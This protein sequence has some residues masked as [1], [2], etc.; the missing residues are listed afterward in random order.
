MRTL[1]LTT[2][3]LLLAAGAALLWHRSPE[4]GR[5]AAPVM[6][7]PSPVAPKASLP[8]PMQ[9]AA[10]VAPTMP[11]LSEQ[12][13]RLIASGNPHAA[14]DAYRLLSNCATFNRDGDRLIFDLQNLRRSDGGLPGFRSMTDG[15]KAHDAHLCTGMTE[16]MRVARL[17]YL[18]M[19][20]RA[21]VMGAAIQ[22]AMEGPFGDLSALQTRPD[23][24]LVQAWK[25]EVQ[26][27]LETAANDADLEA[28]EYISFRQQDGDAVFNKNPA[29]AY[30]YGVARGLIYRELI[31]PAD[32]LHILYAPDG[33][34]M[35]T[36]GASLTAEQRAAELAAATR[37]AALAKARL[38][39][40]P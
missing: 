8:L 12:V 28:L 19:A 38:Q 2:A 16:R 11:T 22:M 26:A 23:D 1:T 21:G 25:Q 36:V 18:A 3:A 37:I 27:L 14:F 9:P 4:P 34:L 31:G 30:R 5:A 24:P 17:D 39:Q 15:E 6:P 33:E 13:D 10:P 7:A 29:L 40:T 35:R 20:A 32:T